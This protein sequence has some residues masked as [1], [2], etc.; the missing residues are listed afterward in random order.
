MHNQTRGKHA[1]H[2]YDERDTSKLTAVVK[3]RI[4][5][6]SD[7]K[8]IMTTIK[9]NTRSEKMTRSITKI[10]RRNPRLIGRGEMLY[11]KEIP[12]L[13]AKFRSVQ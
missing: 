4:P 12:G 8:P 10:Q 6:I 13:L 2:S 1:R 5:N 3:P 7:H 9:P 11:T